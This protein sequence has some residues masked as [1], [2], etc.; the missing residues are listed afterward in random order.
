M[1]AEFLGADAV[2]Q[3]HGYHQPRP[4]ALEVHHI[5]PLGMLGPN[6]ASNKVVVCPTGHTNIHKILHL[7]CQGLPV[8]AGGRR[9]RAVA[10]SGYDQWLAAGKPGRPG[11]M[12]SR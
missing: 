5:W 2:C 7:L 12:A 3:V 4:L 9:E 11:L 10:Q 1:E 8:I 6:I